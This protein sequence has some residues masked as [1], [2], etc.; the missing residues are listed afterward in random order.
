MISKDAEFDMSVIQQD[1]NAPQY[2]EA[3]SIL[4][5]CTIPR[6]F[7]NSFVV[8]CIPYIL[9]AG[10]SLRSLD[11]GAYELRHTTFL[12]R[13]LQNTSNEFN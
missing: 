3:L 6:V 5:V 13:F 8:R 10:F 7:V 4:L 1:R 12:S 2:E 9:K 11:L